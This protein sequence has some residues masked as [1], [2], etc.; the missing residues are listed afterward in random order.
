MSTTFNDLLLE[1]GI[2][3]NEVALLRHHT[4]QCGAS[5]AS[6]ADRKSVV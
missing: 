4:P 6:I 1:Q 2:V 3:P 5:A